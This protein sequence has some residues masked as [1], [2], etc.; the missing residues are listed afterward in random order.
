MRIKKINRGSITHVRVRVHVMSVRVVDLGCFALSSLLAQAREKARESSK[1]WDTAL[2]SFMSTTSLT[3]L[4]G[5][6]WGYS[7]LLILF[8]FSTKV[9]CPARSASKNVVAPQRSNLGLPWF[10]CAGVLQFM[11]SY[12]GYVHQ[13]SCDWRLQVICSEDSD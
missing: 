13:R 10:A 4:E 12:S 2:L 6:A 9:E 11:D 8:D 3:S 1:K 5:W 7:Q